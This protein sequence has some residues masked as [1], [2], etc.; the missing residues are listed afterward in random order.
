MRDI[1]SVKYQCALRAPIDNEERKRKEF[2][3]GH[4]IRNRDKLNFNGEAKMDE[5]TRFRGLQKYHLLLSPAIFCPGRAKGID[6]LS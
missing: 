2:E 1:H 3:I 5:W 4:R 6:A